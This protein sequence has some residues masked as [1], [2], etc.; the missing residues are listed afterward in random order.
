MKDDIHHKRKSY[1]YHELNIKE[2][3]SR[4]IRAFIPKFKHV[5][6]A[7]KTFAEFKLSILPVLNDKEEYV[8]Y[9]NPADIIKNMGAMLSF[10]SPGGILILTM[11]D[12]DFFMSQVAQIV[13]SNDAKIFLTVS[14]GISA[15]INLFIFSN[16]R[17]T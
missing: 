13:E 14:F 12:N 9:I 5:F 3:T 10:N 2:G 11:N 4:I 16:E 6:D 15:P 1:F 8:G 17:N 7:I